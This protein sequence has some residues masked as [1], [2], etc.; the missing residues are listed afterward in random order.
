MAIFGFGRDSDPEDE[1]VVDGT[2][3]PHAQPSEVPEQDRY[4]TVDFESFP[5]SDGMELL[6]SR[7]RRKSYECP[8]YIADAL[9][10]CMQFQTLD[11]HLSD[12]AARYH[13]GAQE[14]SPVAEQLQ[15]L[16]DQGFFVS[17]A[18]F[19]AAM[20]AG[21]C[22]PD[23]APAID[24]V[25]IV[26]AGR[27]ES[28]KR[29]LEGHLDLAAKHGRQH[30]LVVFDDSHDEAICA[31]SR[32]LIAALAADRGVPISYAGP[33]DRE[34][35]LSA[36]AA[37]L[38]SDGVPEQLLRW[39]LFGPPEIRATP[40][41]NRNCLLLHC[42]GRVYLGMDDDVE[43]RTAAVPGQH[44]GLLLTSDEP[45]EFRCF[46]SREDAFAALEYGDEDLLSL[47][48]RLL[49][50]PIS[51]IAR[52][53]S[54]TRLD[55]HLITPPFLRRLMNGT[56]RVRVTLSG[57]VGDSGMSLPC[58]FLFATGTKR[59]RLWGSEDVYHNACT[60]RAVL[61]AVNGWTVTEHARVMMPATGVDCRDLLPPFAPAVWDHD[62]LF[63]VTLR[64][65]FPNACIGHVPRA[66][67]HDPPGERNYEK[68]D[69]W[70]KVVR[71]R[72]SDYLGRFVKRCGYG[73]QAREPRP[74]LEYLGRYLRG[75]ATLDRADLEEV[76]RVER[77]R[78]LGECARHLEAELDLSEP[79]EH[80]ARDMTSC[81][82][83][84]SATS[85]SDDCV[86]PVDLEGVAGVDDPIDWFAGHLEHFGALLEAW[87]IVVDAACRLR[88]KGELPAH[89]L[90]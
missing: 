35:Y 77:W 48:E 80:I 76:L 24:T 36:L 63:G 17:L 69:V 5:S 88:E 37:E 30:D 7:T 58:H 10:Q 82:E 12:T 44:D 27:V 74:R 1:P 6:Y 52:M 79:P 47:H 84:I 73:P 78:H 33:E 25:G 14:L 56:V 59:E 19:R 86:A 4:R 75:I 34:P 50:K 67:R 38:A 32:S 15:R 31:K 16:A 83:H 29:C 54:D 42:A 46:A 53:H 20:A 22:E 60:T 21:A 71:L 43:C 3:E 41:A 62:G 66:V 57:L 90:G 49:A 18:E 68:D 28:L 64:S 23:D 9:A 45:T 65:C 51:Y 72:T 89:P 2:D 70:R 87:P 40:G 11:Q 85:G 26:T 61:R 39:A 55:A 81:L 13:I 8:S